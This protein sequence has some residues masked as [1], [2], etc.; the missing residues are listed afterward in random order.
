[1]IKKWGGVDQVTD[2]TP[3]KARCSRLKLSHPPA[4]TTGESRYHLMDHFKACFK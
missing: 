1:V 4:W 2:S 3:P